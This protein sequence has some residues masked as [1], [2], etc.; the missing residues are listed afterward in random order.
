MGRPLAKRYFGNKNNDGVGGEGVSGV[1]FSNIGLGYYSANVAITFSAPTLT[2]GTT[3]TATA[4]TL[5][6]NGAINGVTISGGTGYVSAPTVTITGANTYTAVAT[7]TLTAAIDNAI[8]ANAFIPGGSSSVEA[9]ILA[10]KGSR[11]YRVAT[12]QGTGVCSLTNTTV[13]EGFMEILATDS[14]GS[15]YYVIKLTST[16]A[17]LVQKDDNGSGFDYSS[18]QRAGWTI[19]GSAVAPTASTIGTVVLDSI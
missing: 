5:H 6:G 17:V 9:D 11:R 12:A 14:L 19:T 13:A 1:T 4:I 15:T 16:E 8:R 7:S 3:A 2:G 18:N 10:Q